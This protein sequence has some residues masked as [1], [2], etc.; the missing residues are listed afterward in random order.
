MM[1]CGVTKFTI[2][3]W[4]RGSLQTRH[5]LTSQVQARFSWFAKEF[6]RREK[7]NI[8]WIRHLRRFLGETIC[9][10]WNCNMRCPYE[11]AHFWGFSFFVGE[12]NTHYYNPKIGGCVLTTVWQV[13]VESWVQTCHYK[14]CQWRRIMIKTKRS[15]KITTTLSLITVLSLTRV[16][17][18]VKRRRSVS[19]H[20]D[21]MLLSYY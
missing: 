3:K 18:V 19:C 20:V 7:I 10:Q 14:S 12:K 13:M 9:P 6:P 17:S 8:Q 1:H 21:D 2:L 11:Q 5:N 4:K 16:K 15:P